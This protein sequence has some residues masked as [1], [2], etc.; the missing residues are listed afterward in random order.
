MAL[1]YQVLYKNYK[2]L[3]Y[4]TFKKARSDI[5]V[6]LCKIS[7]KN[8]CK[9]RNYDFLK[10]MGHMCPISTGGVKTKVSFLRLVS[11]LALAKILSSDVCP[12]SMAAVAKIDVVMQKMASESVSVPSGYKLYTT[13]CSGQFS[14]DR[15]HFGPSHHVWLIT[16]SS[17]FCSL[18][19]M[20]AGFMF[21]GTW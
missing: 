7:Q 8:T 15:S 5:F 11:K 16:K 4:V 18:V 13:S 19:M 20:S 6:N 12:T 3:K 1:I 14:C 17:A 21:V 10:T 9:Q 2:V